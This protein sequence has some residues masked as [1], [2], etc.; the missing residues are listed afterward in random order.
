M[1]EQDVDWME[2]VNDAQKC[3]LSGLYVV[4]KNASE[5]ETPLI[6]TNT[7]GYIYLKPNDFVMPQNNCNL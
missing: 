4:P 1:S 3:C 2:D 5:L 7:T 6:L